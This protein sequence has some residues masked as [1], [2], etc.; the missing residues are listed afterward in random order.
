MKSCRKKQ[1]KTNKKHGKKTSGCECE[2]FKAR[3]AYLMSLKQDPKQLVNN[4]CIMHERIKGS[5]EVYKSF[6]RSETFLDE[7]GE[8]KPLLLVPKNVENF[9]DMMV[10][11]IEN[12]NDFYNGVLVKLVF[13][14]CEMAESSINTE[15][16]VEMFPMVYGLDVLMK[17]FFYQKFFPSMANILNSFR[18][19]KGL[20][21]RILRLTTEE[22]KKLKL[23]LVGL[24][25]RTQ[26]TIMEKRF[27]CLMYK[28]KLSLF[29]SIKFDRDF[30]DYTPVVGNFETLSKQKQVEELARVYQMYQDFCINTSYNGSTMLKGENYLLWHY[31]TYQAPGTVQANKQSK[32]KEVKFVE[33]PTLIISKKP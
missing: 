6:I 17:V 3:K 14:T 16:F 15:A 10:V 26:T 19:K 18:K 5:F 4:L 12:K 30:V 25:C 1:N 8:E 28:T 29:P 20:P 11:I 23:K 24:M 7:N 22:Y 21:R 9:F 32:T 27:H 33:S 13:R 31:I 2:T